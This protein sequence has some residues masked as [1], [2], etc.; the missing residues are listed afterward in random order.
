[1]NRILLL[2]LAGVTGGMLATASAEDEAARLSSPIGTPK[3]EGAA[4][5]LSGNFYFC[6]MQADGLDLNEAGNVGVIR[7]GAAE[8]EVFVALPA[9]IRGNGLRVGPDGGLYLAD[10]L[11]GKVVRIDLETREVTIVHDFEVKNPKW[12]Q[13]PNDLAITPDGKRLY[14]S[15]VGAGLWTMTLQGEDVKK[16]S[17]KGTNGVEV[18]PDGKLLYASHG[19]Y[20]IQPDGTL[21]DTGIKPNLPKEGWAYTDGMRA[22][23]EGNLYISR[24]GGRVPDE[25]GKRVQQ[26]GG[27]HVVAPDGSLLR[28]IRVD[29][30]R[31]HNV[32]FGG[33]VG[34]TLFLICPG[35]D[36]FVAKWENDVPGAYLANLER[37]ADE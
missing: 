19:F 6:N 13:T 29:H 12:T 10:Q 26:R 3:M 1:M 11:G 35:R 33:P 36:G 27:V 15:R 21:E 8:P 24:A 37:W 14:I 23:A 25:N 30:P 9:G 4:S 20:S 7:P 18:S 32:G 17:G 22:D 34:K 2:L 5:D 16:V 28:T 31:V